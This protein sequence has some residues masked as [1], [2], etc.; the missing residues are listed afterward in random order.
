MHLNRL[1]RT[2]CENTLH[3]LSGLR[4]MTRMNPDATAER[5]GFILWSTS[6]VHCENITIFVHQ[7]VF[8]LSALSIK[9]KDLWVS[10]S[11]IS[12]NIN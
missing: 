3:V 8:L 9:Q 4:S 12:P 6:F 1:K 11:F 5:L 2:E 10:S 7:V